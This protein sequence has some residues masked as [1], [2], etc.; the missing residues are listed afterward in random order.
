MKPERRPHVRLLLIL[1][2]V[3]AANVIVYVAAVNLFDDPFIVGA[4]VA[5]ASSV[6]LLVQYALVLRTLKDINAAASRMVELDFS[7]KCREPL[8]KEFTDLAATV[9]RLSESLEANVANL[10]E[11][12]RQ[13]SQELAERKR[14]QQLTK[15][16]ISHL[17]HDLKTPIAIISG[18]AEGLT[19]GLAKTPEQRDRYAGM[20]SAESNHMR[21]IV[22]K[23][24]TLSRAEAKKATADLVDFDLAAMLRDILPRFEMEIH[25]E[26]LTLTTDI[27]ETLQV[28]SET[29]SVEQ[30][31]INYIQNAIYHNGG[32]KLSVRLS[33]TEGGM[34]RLSVVNDAEPISEDDAPHI[35]EKLYRIDR[36]RSRN[37]GEAGL[38]LNIVRQNCERL[39]LPYG[40]RNLDHAV[41]F[42]IEVPLHAKPAAAP[43]AAPVPKD[44][45]KGRTRRFRRNKGE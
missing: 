23:L 32:T 5:A 6:T 18:Y 34:A 1:L 2:A 21:E 38:G 37:H 12:N 10:H 15:D 26:G 13:L 45:P 24:L 44:E 8:T 27:P 16:V 25:N 33:T 17:S 28:H 19:V 4:V 31:A 42:Y 41:E 43:Q 22:E 35:W 11:S 36:A 3:I 7:R 30:A 14:Q 20:I 40:F 9:N 29:E 39:G